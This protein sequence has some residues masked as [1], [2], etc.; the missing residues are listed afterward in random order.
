M[1]D[2]L[3]ERGQG[4]TGNLGSI[5]AESDETVHGMRQ[6]ADAVSRLSQRTGELKSL[7]ECLLGEQEAECGTDLAGRRALAAAS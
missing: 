3:A 4:N 7:I 1:S 2:A 6:A 5:R